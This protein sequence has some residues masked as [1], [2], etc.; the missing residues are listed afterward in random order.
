[1]LVSLLFAPYCWL[2]DQCLAMPAIVDA[3]YAAR[4][5]FPI[6]ALAFV[7]LAADIQLCIVKVI[8]PLWLWTAPAWLAFYLFARASASTPVVGPA[9]AIPGM[10]EQ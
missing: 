3:A 7:I 6:V 4:S 8:S 9:K 10:V 5:R 2:Y 1:M